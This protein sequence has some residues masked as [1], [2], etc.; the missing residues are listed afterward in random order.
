MAVE[1][2]RTGGCRCGKIRFRVSGTPIGG[3]ACHCRDCQYAAGGSANLTWIFSKAHF[4]I[5]RGVPSCYQARPESGGT[6]FCVHCGTHLFSYPDSN[7]DLVAIK[8]GSL[9]D[10]TGFAVGAD[11]WMGSAPPWHRSHA[12]ALQFERNIEA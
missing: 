3:V 9:D 2:D 12:N 7:P 4:S 10:A 8:I 5:H 1:V 6:F 11:I